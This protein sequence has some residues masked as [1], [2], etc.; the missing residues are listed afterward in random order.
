M[1]YR[2][3]DQDS[4]FDASFEQSLDVIVAAPVRSPNGNSPNIVFG[5]SK[6]LMGWTVGGGVEHAITDHWTVKGEYQYYRFDAEIPLS[7]PNGTL[8]RIFID[9]LDV[10]A[11]TFAV[12]YKL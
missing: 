6:T 12:A 8:A 4:G 3:E 1:R 5:G 2:G 7:F 9:K 11:V 10:H